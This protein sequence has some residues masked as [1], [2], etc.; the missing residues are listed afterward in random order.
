MKVFISAPYERGSVQGNCITAE[1]LVSFF[2]DSGVDASVLYLGDRVGAGDVLVALHARKSRHFI[3]DFLLLNAGGRVVV[4]LTGTDLYSDIRGGCEVCLSSLELADVIVISQGASMASVPDAFK[5]KVVVVHKSIDLPEG[6]V[7][8]LELVDDGDEALEVGLI[9]VVGHLRAVKQPFL[10]VEALSVLNE[11]CEV[12]LVLLGNVVDAEM[13]EIGEEWCRRESRFRWFRGVEH[14]DALRWVRRSLVTV[15]SSLAEGGANSV[16]ESIVL[17]VPVLATR[18]EGNVGM[19]GE[20]YEGYFG[21]G[22]VGEL[23]ALMK[24]VLVDAV[25]LSRLR[26]QVGVR[27][28]LLR[29]EREKLG[30]MQLLE[31]IL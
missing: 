30:W 1:R 24:R 14:V 11:E 19:L 18:V 20:D 29:P 25:F 28:G 8:D 23:A 2:L 27:A 26:E 13:L 7:S 6:F 5:S 9:S 17:G 10:A 21:V 22:D 12:E 4:Y 31:N 15:N 16:G 3:D